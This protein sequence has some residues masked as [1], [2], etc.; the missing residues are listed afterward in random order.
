MKILSI[1]TIVFVIF[2]AVGF[3]TL[4][5]DGTITGYVTKAKDTNQNAVDKVDDITNS[6]VALKA[7]D[8][9]ANLLQKKT[10]IVDSLEAL[11]EK[12]E[13]QKYVDSAALIVDIDKKI[14]ELDDPEISEIWSD[15]NGCLCSACGEN[16]Y[17]EL[18]DLINEN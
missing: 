17:S 6:D 4:W 10:N 7:K 14:A 13:D 18:I 12:I 1:F 11:E 8:L 3:L 16:K 15:M 9:V 5:N 2:A